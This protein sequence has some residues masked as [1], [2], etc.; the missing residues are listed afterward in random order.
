M[1]TVAESVAGA[2]ERLK[3]TFPI[4]ERGNRGHLSYPDLSYAGILHETYDKARLTDIISALLSPSFSA[5]HT[6]ST[7]LSP[8]CVKKAGA[9]FK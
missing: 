8:N 2:M 1:I 4:D 5:L 7:S 9:F 6:L 3:A